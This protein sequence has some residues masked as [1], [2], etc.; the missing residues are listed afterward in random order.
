MNPQT[1]KK[2]N[3]PYSILWNIE[4]QDPPTCN[5]PEGSGA[6]DSIVVFSI[7][8]SDEQ[9]EMRTGATSTAFYSQNGRTREELTPSELFQSWA[10][11]AAHLS[12]QLPEGPEK[13]FCASVRA[14]VTK[15]VVSR[16]NQS[17]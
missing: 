4:F 11:M 13:A 17:H 12:E 6:C 1:A 3:M 7:L 8:H 14:A 9:T 2:K 5:P 15:D 10:V 16:R